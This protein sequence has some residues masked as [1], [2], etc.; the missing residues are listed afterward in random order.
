MICGA[1]LSLTEDHA[2]SEA[3]VEKYVEFYRKNKIR[4]HHK[5]CNDRPFFQLKKQNGNIVLAEDD[6]PV[7]LHTL[8]D[9]TSKTPLNSPKNLLPSEWVFGKLDELHKVN[10]NTEM[11][12][13]KPSGVKSLVKNFTE[14][15]SFKG[16]NNEVKKYLKNCTTCA[17]N[18]S[19][20]PTHPPPPIPIRSYH[21]FHR[22]QFDLVDI[23]TKAREHLRNNAWGYRYILVIKDCFSK[24]CWLFPLQKKEAPLIY[25][26][27]SFLFQIEG[28]PIIFQSDNGKEF[29]AEILSSF[30]RKNSV[31]IKHGKPY[32]PQS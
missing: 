30:L 11:E 29:V 14:V 16:I 13:C 24:F 1:L 10:L 22:V 32:H 23:G 26:A 17:L 4:F 5:K 2:F 9:N 25:N 6:R 15:Y 12:S 28:Y 19:F 7:I 8:Y 21:P 18:K 31:E 27:A 20:L 3:E